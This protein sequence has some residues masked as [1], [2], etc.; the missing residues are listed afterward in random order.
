MNQPATYTGRK[1][2]TATR[3]AVLLSDK[4]A[5]FV[6]TLGGLATIAAVLLVGV[7][8]FVVALPLFRSATT[9]LKQSIA[10][11]L[12]NDQLLASG[13]DES[14]SLAWFCNADEIAVIEIKTGNK[15]LS[16]STESCGL[17]QA[18]VIS[19]PQGNLRSAFGFKDGTI[20]TGRIGLITSYVPQTKIPRQADTLNVGE[21]ITV[22]NVIYLR[23]SKDITK[24]IELLADLDEPI[25]AGLT[26]PIINID[27]TMTS[28]GFCV[29]AIDDQGNI[30]VKKSSFQK[31]LITDE[32]SVSTLETTIKGEQD[33]SDF[34]FVRV[35]GLGDQLF[36]FTPSG[37][38][39]RFVI[40]D[41]TN[42]ELMEQYQLLQK[43]QLI[44]HITR[45]FG[46]ASFV[47]GDNSGT[48]RILFT[49]RDT[50]LTTKDG[51]ETKITATFASQPNG[52][53]QQRRDARITAISSSPRS[54]LF[55]VASADGFIRL[56]QAT[57]H[58]I[59]AEINSMKESVLTEKPRVLLLG[60]REQTLV[61]YDGRNLASWDITPGYPEVSFGA[62]FGKIWYENYPGRDYAWET[63]G[64]E[65]F[66]PKYSLVP[67]LFGTIKA[68]IYS[69]LF[70]TPIAIFAAI[71][72]SQFMT[73]SW[74][75]RIKPIIEMMASL[76]SV[77]LGFIAGLILAPLIESRAMVFVTSL[78]TVPIML[79]VG[80][81]L[82]Q[83]WPPGLRG[84]VSSWRFPVVL[85]VALPLG[86]LLGSVVAKPTESLLFDG[87]FFAWLNGRG[88][89]GWGGW[90]LALF[91]LSAMVA[92]LVISRFI[93]PWIRQRSRKWGHWK[94]VFTAFFLFIIGFFLAG[95][96][97]TAA[98]M[99]LDALRLETRS[100]IFGTY[101]Q[102]NTMIVA[103]GMSFA[104][105]PLI[106]TIAD[107]A[108]SSVPD[109]LRS[110]SLG[111]GATPWQT[112]IRI[113]L[114]TAAS[115][116]FS[117]VMIGLGRAIG[118]TMIVLMA[119]GNTPIMNWNI[120]SGF[121]TLSATIAT[122]LPEATQGSTHYRILFLAAVLLFVLTFFINT[123]AE[124]IRQRFRR[125]AHEL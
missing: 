103:I 38:F 108:L 83:L 70:A 63:T 105:I 48:I 58:S 21:L 56:L 104:I 22:D 26:R 12:P 68:T 36:V 3:A 5:L 41:V 6:I 29:A 47:L 2:S 112:T 73:P 28:N 23:S 50:G 124:L 115:G 84:R 40:R 39:K 101:V 98:A 8:L 64:H 17:Q 95:A 59:V 102:R 18:S 42:P 77:V 89:S 1:K 19:H 30:H 86:I 44:T 7:F 54:R 97:S 55:A 99:F 117:A 125:R 24:K 46:G 20:R 116:L 118:E 49:S 100:G 31:N 15:L 51:L 32:S 67:L 90:T 34:R 62:L 61:A 69:M 27:F 81:F 121:Q 10:F 111:T 75:S 92:A 122:E 91:P 60:S 123:V 57:N 52:S 14:G 119:A 96:I 88:A 80:A 82:W 53:H 66:E 113:I 109:H 16:R 35:S 25:S 93:N 79:L 76:P 43:N 94:T 87:D 13:L 78:F 71:Y 107:D 106:F 74:K 65:S 72:V 120:F 110:G 45:L 33:D 85:V 4:L 37:V 11:N 9:E 114:P